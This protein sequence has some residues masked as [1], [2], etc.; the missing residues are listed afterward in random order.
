MYKRFIKVL[1]FLLILLLFC[2]L[3]PGSHLCD[4]HNT[5]DISTSISTRK[6]KHVPF[7]LCL[8]LCTSQLKPPPFG[9]RGRVGDN[10]GIKSLLNNKLSPE[11]GSFD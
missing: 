11:G 9:S 10:R 1:L 4:K 8:C 3:K 7:F 5:S 2:D 6:K